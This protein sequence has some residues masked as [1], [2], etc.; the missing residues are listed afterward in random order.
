[1]TLR[2]LRPFYV[3]APISYDYELRSRVSVT[4]GTGVWRVQRISF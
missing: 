2:R 3:S 4:I 1:M